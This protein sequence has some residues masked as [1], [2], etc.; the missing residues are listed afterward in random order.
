MQFSRIFLT[1]SSYAKVHL[2][3]FKLFLCNYLFLGLQIFMEYL[4]KY[5]YCTKYCA[6]QCIYHITAVVYS[7]AHSVF[8]QSEQKGWQNHSGPLT[9]STLHLWTVTVSSGRRYRALST[10]TTRHRNSFFPQAIHLTNTWQ[11]TWNTQHYFTLFI[12]H[13]YLFSFQFAHF[14]P[15]HT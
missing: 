3:C 11:W 6:L 10:R 9:P 2:M 12:H 15:V 14:I 1:C 4:C 8:I 5:Y 7:T 13:T